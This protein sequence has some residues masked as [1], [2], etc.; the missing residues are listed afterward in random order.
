M[1]GESQVDVDTTERRQRVRSDHK[2][3]GDSRGDMGGGGYRGGVI[4]VTIRYDAGSEV[5]HLYS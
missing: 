5:G 4:I 1:V 2:Q 3:V